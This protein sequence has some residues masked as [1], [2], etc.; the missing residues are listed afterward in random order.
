MN[1]LTYFVVIITAMDQMRV[2]NG[3]KPLNAI[4]VRSMIEHGVGKE[5]KYCFVVEAES[6]ANA[7][8]IVRDL[9]NIKF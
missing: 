8:F 1:E 3:M 4:M 9:F 6:Q 7:R 2:S 5:F